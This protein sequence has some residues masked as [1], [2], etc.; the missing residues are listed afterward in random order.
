M[1]ETAQNNW[2]PTVFP[3]S[4]L[5]ED[6]ERY[7]PADLREWEYHEKMLRLAQGIPNPFTRKLFDPGHFTASAFVISPCKESILLILHGKFDI[8]V[9]PGGHIDPEDDTPMHAAMRETEEETGLQRKHIEPVNLPHGPIFD[10]DIHP[11]P[12]KSKRN[13]PAHHHFDL[14]FL[15]Q[16]TDTQ[17]TPGSDAKE[18]QWE[19]LAN[20]CNVETDESVMRAIRKI[21]KHLN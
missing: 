16:A 21:R 20:M 11:I 19:N 12:S 18:A 14:R 10:I 1:H 5:V 17:L 4:P 9:Q 13:E 6:L 15:F 7:I 3:M 2:P 8:W